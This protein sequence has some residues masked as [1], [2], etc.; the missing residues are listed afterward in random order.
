V[1][2]EVAV[3]A[4]IGKIVAIGVK[5]E[6]KIGKEEKGGEGMI[7]AG[8]G[9]GIAIEV[10]KEGVRGVK[11]G[12]LSEREVGIGIVS[13]SVS[14]VGIEGEKEAVSGRGVGIGRASERRVKRGGEKE[15]GNEVVR[16]KR[17]LDH[18]S[19]KRYYH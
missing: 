17:G 10:E 15:V 8:G 3:G 16:E 9:R 13:V 4:K 14:G 6:E 11:I 1:K 19:L 2:S 7:R 18:P 12:I 5:I